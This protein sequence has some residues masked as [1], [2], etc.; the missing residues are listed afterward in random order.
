MRGMNQLSPSPESG[1]SPSE[2]FTAWQEILGHK[3]QFPVLVQEIQ[4]TVYNGK[5]INEQYHI[6]YNGNSVCVPIIP[7]SLFQRSR[8]DDAPS[9]ILNLLEAEL[10]PDAMATNSGQLIT[11]FLETALLHPY[12]LLNCIPLTKSLF[13]THQSVDFSRPN[14]FVKRTAMLFAINTSMISGHLDLNESNYHSYSNGYSTHENIVKILD[15]MNQK[16]GVGVYPEY[17]CYVDDIA[18][19]AM[20]SQRYLQGK[21]VELEV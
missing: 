21:K 3:V 10:G 14:E 15:N 8:V 9:Q 2:N 13:K 20:Q 19:L 6:D 11:L 7:F 4:H 5:N 1:N 18:F 16:L 12:D 17:D